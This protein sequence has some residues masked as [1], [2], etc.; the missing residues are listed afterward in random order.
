MTAGCGR[1]PIADISDQDQLTLYSID[2]KRFGPGKNP[3]A[4]ETF[5]DYPVLGHF[6][7]IDGQQRRDLLAALRKGM[8]DGKQ[9]AKCFW[10]RHAIRIVSGGKITDY[11]ICFECYHVHIYSDESVTVRPIDGKQQ[12]AFDRVLKDAGIPIAP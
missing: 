11:L 10:P 5:H 7:V 12:E 8:S 9:T 1:N 6:D 2:G 4:A 3:D